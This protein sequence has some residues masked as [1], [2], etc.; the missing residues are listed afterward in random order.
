[1]DMYTLLYLKWT[2][3]KNLLYNT[4]NSVKCYVA[5][6][7]GREFGGE[8]IHVYVWLNPFAVYLKLLQHCSSVIPQYTI[9]SFKK[10]KQSATVPSL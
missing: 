4:E 5:I 1:M 6:W 10:Q 9:K 3:N 8:W 7:M 2:T